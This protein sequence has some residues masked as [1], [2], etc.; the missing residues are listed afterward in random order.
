MKLML[1]IG[2]TMILML[3]SGRA[4]DALETNQTCKACHPLVFKQWQ[5]SMHA[6]STANSDILYQK[7]MQWAI[8]DTKGKA[9]KMC[10]NCHYPYAA[11]AGL[12]EH[13]KARPVDCVFCHSVDQADQPPKFSKVFY[14]GA[15]SDKSDYHSI[16]GREH[17]SDNTLCMRCHD[18]LRNPKQV[19]VCITGME[20]RHSKGM[21]RD[22][23]ICHMPEQGEDD[24]RS[25]TFLGPHNA[26]FLKGSLRLSAVFSDNDSLIIKVDNSQTPHAYPT[27]SPLR[28]VLLKVE[29]FDSSGERIF[30]NWEKNVLKEAPGAAFVR[31]FENDAGQ[32]PVPPWQATAVKMD[33]RI[34]AGEQRTVAYALAPNAFSVRARLLFRLAP[35]NILK[36]LQ[37]DDPYLTQSH[38]IAQIEKQRD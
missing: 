5:S 31:I 9:R 20:V 27:G 25:H 36:R 11:T 6:R 19:E 16:E 7:M 21:E 34:K 10:R 1:Q 28:Q 23:R 2:F 4:S 35:A 33:T 13:Q 29:A 15:S 8:E 12:S 38:L 26:E 32:F 22:C 18:V 37:I 30:S 14:S 3:Q 24:T 17:F